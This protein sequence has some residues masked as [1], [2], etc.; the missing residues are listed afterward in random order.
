M[1]KSEQSE[2]K[3]GSLITAYCLFKKNDKGIALTFNKKKA[4]TSEKVLV[5]K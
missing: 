5:P 3:V 1:K 2:L 4:K